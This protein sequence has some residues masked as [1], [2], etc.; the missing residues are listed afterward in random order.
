SFA[1]TGALLEQLDLLVTVDTATAHLAGALGRP[2]WV[3]LDAAPDWRWM[4]RRTDSPWYPTA[5]IFRQAQLGEWEPLI[6][7]VREALK[8]ELDQRVTK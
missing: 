6:E 2:V 8:V 4:R 7:Q 3:L 1:D 5:R